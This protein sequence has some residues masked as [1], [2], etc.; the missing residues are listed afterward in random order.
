MLA[1]GLLEIRRVPGVLRPAIAVPIPARQGPYVLLDAGANADA[2]P[3]QL[4][5]FAHMGAIFAAEILDILDPEVRLLSIGEEPEKGNALTLEA[6]DLLAASDLR[7]GGNVESRWLLEGGH[8]DVV[9]TDGFTGN[10]CLKALEGAVASLLGGL[11]DRVAATRRGKLGGLLIRPA[12]RALRDRLDP[13]TYGGA[14][15]LGLRGL[16]VIAHGNASHR[17]IANAVRLAA[18]G[19]E[20]DVVGRLESRLPARTPR[21]S[22]V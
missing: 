4:L 12:A 14:Y 2:R 5:Q 8:G 15:L 22:A 13:D 18:R 1:A 19:V 7:F 16:A 3:E 10:V 9:V 17:A 6:H 11:R 20:H 21:A